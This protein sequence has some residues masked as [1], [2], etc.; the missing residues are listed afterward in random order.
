[1]ANVNLAKYAPIGSITEELYDDPLRTAERQRARVHSP[2]RHC[3]IDVRGWIRSFSLPSVVGSKGLPPG[4]GIYSYDKGRRSLFRADLDDRTLKDRG[5]RVNAISPGTI[6]TPGLET[7]YLRLAEP[8]E[9]RRK[10]VAATIPV[11]SVGQAGGGR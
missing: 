3:A 5:I 6:D 10:S 11:G 7:F 8:G 2:E 4:N 1:M 9:Q